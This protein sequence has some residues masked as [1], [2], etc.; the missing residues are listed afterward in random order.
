MAQGSSLS[1]VS[2][3][4]VVG[5]CI[6]AVN[7]NGLFFLSN[8]TRESLLSSPFHEIVSTRKLRS[9]SGRQYTDLKCGNLMVQHVKHLMVVRLLHLSVAMLRQGYRN[10]VKKMILRVL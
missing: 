9:Y 4:K 8:K 3:P 5:E 7:R 1:C 2:H 6:L 10:N